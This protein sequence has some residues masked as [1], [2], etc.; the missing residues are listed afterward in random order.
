MAKRLFLILALSASLFACTPAGG[1]ASSGASLAPVGSDAAPS[2][3]T[4]SMSPSG[5]ASPSAS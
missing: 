1:G 2:V 3:P 4:E 5:S